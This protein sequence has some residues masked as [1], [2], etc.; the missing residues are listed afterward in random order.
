MAV[1]LSAE[2]V[3]NSSH[4]FP[5]FTKARTAAG[6]LFSMIYRKPKTGDPN[7][8]E[9]IVSFF[10][11][12]FKI[13][14]GYSRKCSV[15]GCKVHL[16]TATKTTHYEGPSIHSQPGTN[17]CFSRTIWIREIN[18]YLNDGEVLWYYRRIFGEINNFSHIGREYSFPWNHFYFE[19]LVR[20]S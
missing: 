10:S 12:R 9:K 2:G 16:S 17:R 14:S 1:M 20:P 6:F 18:L 19:I 3:M 11:T 7:E 5:E 4:Y 15:R 8:G 13:S